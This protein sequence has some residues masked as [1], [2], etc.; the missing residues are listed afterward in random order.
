MANLVC[1]ASGLL[2][3]TPNKEGMPAGAVLLSSGSASRL[4]VD[5]RTHGVYTAK[6]DAWYVPGAQAAATDGER[7]ALLLAWH[8]KLNAVKLKRK[9]LRHVQRAAE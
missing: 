1:W 3:V 6:F 9:G 2:Q 8:K 4:T 5:M 7:M